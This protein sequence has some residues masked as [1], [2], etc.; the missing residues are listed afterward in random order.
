M[1]CSGFPINCQ[2]GIIMSLVREYLKQHQETL[3]TAS[4]ETWIDL[5]EVALSDV[6]T[7]IDTKVALECLEEQVA[8]TTEQASLGGYD[9]AFKAVTLLSELE[10][11]AYPSLED[12]GDVVSRRTA[13]TDSINTHHRELGNAIGFALESYTETFGDNL[14]NILASFDESKKKIKDAQ[15][16]DA[17]NEFIKVNHNRIW[18]MVHVDGKPIDSLGVQ[19]DKERQ[20]IESLISHADKVAGVIDPSNTDKKSSGVEK[21]MNSGPKLNLMFNTTTVFKKGHAVFDVRKP[22]IMKNEKKNS[23]YTRGALKGGLV[24][25][26]FFGLA[27]VG[28]AIGA[29]GARATGAKNNIKQ[30]DVNEIRTFLSE[31]YKLAELRSKIEAVANKLDQKVNQADDNKALVKQQAAPVMELLGLIAKHIAN[32][33]HGASILGELVNK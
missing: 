26:F 11:T 13:L 23:D 24:G 8:H 12:Y 9:W 18:A 32:L 17:P 31:A 2:D 27:P 33:L 1:V 5:P 29:L 6:H 16:F 14:K 19:I 4:Q 7:A 22:T 25:L 21:A 20:A 3:P 15:G 10:P 30:S 28:A